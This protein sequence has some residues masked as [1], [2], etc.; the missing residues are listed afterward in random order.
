M[1]VTDPIA[2]LLTRMRNAQHV[3]HEQCTCPW[4]R[5]KEQICEV[6]KKE[7]FISGLSVVGE[8]KDKI[9]TVSFSP[10]HPELTLTRT[11][12]PGRRVYCGKGEIKPVLRGYGVAVVS[13]S[14]GVMTDKEAR[15]EGVGGEVLCA[16]S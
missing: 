16:V 1:P 5:H 11:S 2:D 15:R 10:D 9:I 7:G 6:L 13:T 8:G 14:K 4:S 12:K 3:R